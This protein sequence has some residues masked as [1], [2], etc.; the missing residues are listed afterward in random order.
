MMKLA[1]ASFSLT[2]PR[3]SNQDKLLEPVATPNGTY[4]CAIA[5]GVGGSEGGLEAAEIAITAAADSNGTLSGTES[6]F[7]LS[8]SRM[9]SFV[10]HNNQ[11]ERMATT[12]SVCLIYDYKISVLHV[13]DTRIYHVRSLG[14]N[15]LTQDQTEIAEITA[16]WNIDK[17]SSI[18]LSAKKHP[19]LRPI[20]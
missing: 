7:A 16:A 12:L 9:K 10:S 20:P 14:L 15:D 5:D 6:I 18:A 2:G 4:V 3:E 17:I 8:T 19:H 13:G 11:Y 1:Y